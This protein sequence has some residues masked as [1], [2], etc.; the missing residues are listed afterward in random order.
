MR[1][2]FSALLFAL[3]LVLSFAAST[4]QAAASSG[5]HSSP[6]PITIQDITWE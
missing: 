4:G 6:T 2:R 3:A 1:K 5:G